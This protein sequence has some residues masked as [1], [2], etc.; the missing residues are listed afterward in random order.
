MIEYTEN[1]NLLKIYDQGK[2]DLI[3]AA[4][5]IQAKI[6]EN[7][8]D[9]VTKFIVKFLD[10]MQSR[11]RKQMLWEM[12]HEVISVDG[13]PLTF[14]NSFY[15]FIVNYFYDDSYFRIYWMK[16]K[17]D[18]NFNLIWK[19]QY[20][21]EEEESCEEDEFSKPV[22]KY[23]G[24][25]IGDPLVLMKTMDFFEAKMIQREKED[26]ENEEI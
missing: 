26:L 21:F 16:P 2:L 25:G 1:K 14:M 3:D 19:S 17:Y 22:V 8:N 23:H 20:E 7:R 5:K 13:N 18:E 11:D 6:D 12:F 4:A 10:W 9:D 15:S 24:D